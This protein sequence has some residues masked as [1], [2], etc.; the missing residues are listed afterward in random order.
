MSRHRTKRYREK[1]VSQRDFHHFLYQKRYWG[2]GW[3][4][5][6]RGHWYCGCML[7]RD[8]HS[9]IHGTITTV[10]VPNGN[11]CKRVYN[12]LCR[13]V[14]AGLISDEDEPWTRLENLAILFEEED[15]SIT[16]SILRWQKFKIQKY[17]SYHQRQDSVEGSSK[18]ELLDE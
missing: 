6:L 17:H 4:K 9:D 15:C 18:I 13:Q 1:K 12:E 3:A 10:Y 16:A 14:K 2:N 7:D 11:V 5:A 8:C